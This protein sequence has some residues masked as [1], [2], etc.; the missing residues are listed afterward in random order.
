[1]IYWVFWKHEYNKFKGIRI[2]E[3]NLII[4]GLKNSDISSKLIRKMFGNR[5]YVIETKKFYLK[6]YILNPVY[7][8]NYNLTESVLN[9]EKENISD[10]G[11]SKIQTVKFNNN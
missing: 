1:M 5:K 8:E 9:M 4:F 3:Y 2:Q 10:L 7:L 11:L 6:L